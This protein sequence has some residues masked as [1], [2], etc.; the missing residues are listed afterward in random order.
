MEDKKFNNGLKILGLCMIVV[1]LA[2]GSVMCEDHG[3]SSDNGSGQQYEEA[4]DSNDQDNEKPID[5]E[6]QE[7]LKEAE[8]AYEEELN[9]E[10]AED[11]KDAPSGA[12]GLMDL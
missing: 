12:N 6:E 9:E 8:E 4:V 2:F 1:L 11:A 7:L 3:N 10:A 5:E